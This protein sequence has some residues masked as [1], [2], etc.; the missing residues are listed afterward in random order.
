MKDCCNS[1]VATDSVSLT[2]RPLTYDTGGTATLP[3]CA[4]SNPAAGATVNCPTN[5]PPLG[6]GELGS[7]ALDNSQVYAWNEDVDIQ[8]KVESGAQPV[9]LVNL[10][11]YNEPMASAAVGLPNVELR[12]NSLLDPV[13]YIIL[14]SQDLNE[15]DSQYRSVS[16][17]ITMDI[18]D[19]R[20]TSFTIS[21]S[22]QN[23]SL[24]WAALS[25]IELCAETG[26][27]THQ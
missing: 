5:A 22:F 17:V 15:N 16:L 14:G 12:F 18:R 13:D 26:K 1:T 2:P 9:S 23:T 3:S 8:Y 19:L 7:G 25:E 6:D 24:K 10:Y 21:L 20:Y 27:A 4:P 11:F